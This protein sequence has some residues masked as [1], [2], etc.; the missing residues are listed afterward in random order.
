MKTRRTYPAGREG[1]GDGS[2][3]FNAGR[4]PE[5]RE[6]VSRALPWQSFMWS[7][8]SLI[9]VFSMRLVYTK[10]VAISFVAALQSM[11]AMNQ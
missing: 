10:R 6:P 4:A 2:A 1:A 5:H 3:A 8:S 9:P 7:S 11:L